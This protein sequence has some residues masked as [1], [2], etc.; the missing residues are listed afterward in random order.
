MHRI[1]FKAHYVTNINVL[2]RKPQGKYQPESISVV[3]IDKNNTQDLS[4][5]DEVCNNWVGNIFCDDIKDAANRVFSKPYILSIVA[6]E[7]YLK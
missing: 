4:A 6:E 3:S 2:K 7:K 1:N 5:L